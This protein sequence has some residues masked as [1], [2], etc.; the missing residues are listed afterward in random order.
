MQETPKGHKIP[1]P[2]RKD[3]LADLAKVAKPA[4]PS[5]APV[6]GEGGA[7]RE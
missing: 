6:D 3:V 2:T 4:N 1:V 7:E 5:G